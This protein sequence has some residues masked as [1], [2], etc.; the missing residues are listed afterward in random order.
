M[1]KREHVYQVQG[2]IFQAQEVHAEQAISLVTT[3]N[4]QAKSLMNSRKVPAGGQCPQAVPFFAFFCFDPI[5]LYKFPLFLLYLK[6]KLYLWIAS[7][8]KKV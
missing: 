5:S 3:E 7:A 1:L 8:G 6:L 2:V 4:S